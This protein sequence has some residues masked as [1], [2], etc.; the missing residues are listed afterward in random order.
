MVTP[1]AG[2]A[3]RRNVWAVGGA[4]THALVYIAYTKNIEIVRDHVK[5]HGVTCLL[6]HMIIFNIA[7]TLVACRIYYWHAL[8]SLVSL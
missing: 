4:S 6:S 3:D 8:Q 7:S 2:G 1:G 5:P